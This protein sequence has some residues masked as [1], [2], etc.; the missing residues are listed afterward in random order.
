MGIFL[1]IILSCF[2]GWA[3]TENANRKSEQLQL[4]L[5]AKEREIVALKDEHEFQ[6]R[7]WKRTVEEML[8]QV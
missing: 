2:F 5:T 1:L 4:L 6:K 7:V 8:E 3:F